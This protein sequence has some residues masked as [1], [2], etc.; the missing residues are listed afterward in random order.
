MGRPEDERRSADGD[1]VAVGQPHSV[2]VAEQRVHV[3]RA[4]VA[5]SVLEDVAQC[6]VFLVVFDGNDTMERINARVFR[7]DGLV[8]VRA[9]DVTAQFVSAHVKRNDLLKRKSVFHDDH[10]ATVVLI[11]L[12]VERAFLMDA[13]QP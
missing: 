13:G 9:L 4:R 3:E 8:D 6:A 12:F 11:G 10:T 2:L 1:D 7:L 5:R